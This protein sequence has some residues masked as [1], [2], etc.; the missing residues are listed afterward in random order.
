MKFIEE[1][2]MKFLIIEHSSG[3]YFAFNLS[4]T[5]E[6]STAFGIIQD[7]F[8]FMVMGWKVAKVIP[9]WVLVYSDW[10]DFMSSIKASPSNQEDGKRHAQND[11]NAVYDG[12]DWNNSQIEQARIKSADPLYVADGLFQGDT[13]KSNGIV[14]INESN[15]ATASNTIVDQ[16]LTTK[17][18]V[19][20]ILKR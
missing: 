14:D 8:E 19:R 2:E 20:S 10:K 16:E 12:D 3:K 9:T 18:Q 5:E 13:P 17:A 4:D 1:D 11:D 15:A 6:C 7:K